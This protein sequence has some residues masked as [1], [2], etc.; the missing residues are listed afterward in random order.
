M[1]NVSNSANATMSE[2]LT[3]GGGSL[4]NKTGEVAKKIVSGAVS[5]LGNITGEIQQVI[6][7]K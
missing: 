2:N 6:A 7:G 1:N 5:A 4:L 3:E